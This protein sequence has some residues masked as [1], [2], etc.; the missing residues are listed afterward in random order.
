VNDVTA[1]KA[2]CA[3]RLG[4]ASRLQHEVPRSL[5]EGPEGLDDERGEGGALLLHD[6]AVFLLLR[7]LALL[8]RL[9][10]ALLAVALG[11]AVDDAEVA[12]DDIRAH[13]GAEVTALAAGAPLD[14]R[15]DCAGAA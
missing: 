13:D 11:R 12:D 8:G 10:R 5:A 1:K 15:L 7:P 2:R 9:T 14:P 4:E 3:G 6:L